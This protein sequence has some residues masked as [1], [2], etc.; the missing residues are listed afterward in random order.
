VPAIGRKGTGDG[1]R[2]FPATL[3]II[4]RMFAT[5]GSA[6]LILALLSAIFRMMRWHRYRDLTARIEH[7]SFEFAISDRSFPQRFKKRC[8]WNWFRLQ[9]ERY[10]HRYEYPNVHMLSDVLF[11]VQLRIPSSSRVIPDRDFTFFYRFERQNRETLRKLAFH[12][13]LLRFILL[14]LFSSSFATPFPVSPLIHRDEVIRF[15]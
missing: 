13:F 15:M 1:Y 5:A 4:S 9:T 6:S 3:Q 7:P 10:I 8:L 12:R 2:P 11:H 14:I